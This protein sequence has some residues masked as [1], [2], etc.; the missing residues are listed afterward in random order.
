M[1]FSDKDTTILEQRRITVSN[2]ALL[3]S[4]NN[5]CIPYPFPYRA[6]NHKNVVNDLITLS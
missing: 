4:F 5:L 2:Y 1:G 3:L 6:H